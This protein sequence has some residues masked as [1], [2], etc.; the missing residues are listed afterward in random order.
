MQRSRGRASWVRRTDLS[1]T[2]EGRV[3]TETRHRDRGDGSAPA[4]DITR[5]AYDGFGNLVEHGRTRGLY[6]SDDGVC[7]DDERTVLLQHPRNG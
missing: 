1:Y 7:V 2:S 6:L 5:Y 3:A 4:A